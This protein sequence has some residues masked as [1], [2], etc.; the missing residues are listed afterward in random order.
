M[1]DTALRV[2]DLSKEYRIGAREAVGKTL[3]ETLMGVFQSPVRLAAKLWHRDAARPAEL[4]E[5]IWALKG[6]SFEIKR[7]EVVGIIGRNGAGKSTLLKLLSRITEPTTGLVEIHGRVGS[8]L[9]VGT[10]FHG[11]LTGRENIYLNGSILGMRRGEIQRKFDEIVA[12][13]EVEKF[14]DTPV[15]HYSSGMYLRLAFAVAAH[16]EPEI[17]IVDEVLAVGD[18]NFQRK[19][20]NK[21]QDVGQQGRTVLLVSHN[22]S[23]ITRLCTRA[24]LIDQGKII[25]DGSSNQIVNTYLSSGIATTAVREWSD[26]TTAPGGEVARLRA[27]RVRSEDG[28]ITD[29]ADIRRPVAIEMEYDVL[30]PGYVLMPYY[31]FHTQEG[32]TAFEAIDLDPAWRGRPRPVGRWVSVASIPGNLLSEGILSIS[33]GLVTLDPVI[34]QFREQDAVAFQVIDNQDGDSARGDWTGP[35]VGF[36]RPLLQWNTLFSSVNGQGREMGTEGTKHEVL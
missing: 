18:V 8:L 13:A 32:L 15:K 30:K 11:E 16:L 29:T 20:L 36:V 25:Q 7:G 27:V 6:L 9:E 10:G 19:C 33:P 28:Q 2:E 1:T 35:F 23:A 24:I 31:Q 3:R 22:M 5:T 14:I 12:F 34:K 26:L 17:L 21:M 4:T